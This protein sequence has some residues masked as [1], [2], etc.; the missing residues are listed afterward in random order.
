MS[1]R[2]QDFVYNIEYV[3]GRNN[4]LADYLSRM[5]TEILEWDADV[6]EELQIALIH[7]D[8]ALS[9][10]EEPIKKR[11]V[12]DFLEDIRME[13]NKVSD[14]SM[15]D[16][17][18]DVVVSER[19]SECIDENLENEEVPA[20]VTSD[21]GESVI[22]ENV[23]SM[24]KHLAFGNADSAPKGCDNKEG[25]RCVVFVMNCMYVIIKMY[26]CEA[27]AC[28]RSDSRVGDSGGGGGDR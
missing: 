1:M 2:L 21:V 19:N 18:E 10:K 27:V 28:L 25:G 4:V 17:I 12:D 15:S 16:R 3:P 26:L 8:E 22:G 13:E 14:N 5:P 7:D 9:I 6:A 24:E 23:R 20:C 11:N